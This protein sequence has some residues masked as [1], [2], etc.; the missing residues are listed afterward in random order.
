MSVKSKEQV[1]SYLDESAAA[2]DARKNF[3]EKILT[4][5]EEWVK[6]QK[7]ETRDTFDTLLKANGIKPA[8][9]TLSPDRRRDITTPNEVY[10]IRGPT[11]CGKTYMV[12]EQ[13]KKKDIYMCNPLYR[14]CWDNYNGENVVLIENFV[15]GISYSTMLQMCGQTHAFVK[16]GDEKPNPIPFLAKKIYITSIHKPE[17]IYPTAMANKK[18]LPE[19]RKLITKE[20][21]FEVK[22][23][24]LQKTDK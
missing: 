7:K 1:K 4:E 23:E 9:T 15:N 13:E 20:I 14:D 11:K 17:F 5:L 18:E 22:P 12:F 10:W 16:S 24:Y 21:A 19:L 2:I 6:S 8:T 3:G